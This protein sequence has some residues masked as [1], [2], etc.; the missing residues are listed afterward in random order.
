MKTYYTT[1]TIGDAYVIVCKLYVVAKQEQILCKHYSGLEEVERTIREVYSL[2]PNINVE[3][4][5]KRSSD[6]NVWGTFEPCQLKQEWSRY[7]LKQPKYYPEF[8][9]GN[10]SHFNLPDAYVTLQIKAG[11]HAPYSRSLSIDTIREILN[12]SKL[13]VVIIGEKT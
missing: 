10:L 4:I 6:I 3:F 5:N 11:T 12:G 2:I 1:G 7:N 13:P 9:L 8:E